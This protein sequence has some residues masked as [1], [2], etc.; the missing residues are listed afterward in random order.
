MQKRASIVEARRDLGRL[1]EEVRRTGQPV[2]PTR[3]G[4]AVAQIVP[5][6]RRQATW[7]RSR[8]AFAELRGTVRRHPEGFF[9]QERGRA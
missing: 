4:H 7:R 8:D 1:A 2:V 5:E 6:P 9:H 3:R